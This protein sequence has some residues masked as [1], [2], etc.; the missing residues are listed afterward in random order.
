MN[1]RRFDEDFDRE[2]L[3]GSDNI[4]D[5]MLIGKKSVNG[6]VIM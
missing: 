1:I 4:N 2:P 6:I 5:Y 3:R